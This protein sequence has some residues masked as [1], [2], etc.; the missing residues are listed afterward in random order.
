[1]SCPVR[2][3]YFAQKTIPLT[4]NR[5]YE[6]YPD[7]FGSTLEL[8]HAGEVWKGNAKSVKQLETEQMTAAKQNIKIRRLADPAKALAVGSLRSALLCASLTNTPLSSG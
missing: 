2:H 3:E 4:I 5:N 1:M 6:V 7:K 8:E